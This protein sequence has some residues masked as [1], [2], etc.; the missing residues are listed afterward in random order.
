MPESKTPIGRESTQGKNARVGDW[1]QPVPDT[2]VPLG[3][4]R[5]R[6]LALIAVV[7][8]AFAPRRARGHL[9]EAR[10]RR[11]DG[12]RHD[13]HDQRLHPRRRAADRRLAGSDPRPRTRREPPGHEPDRRAVLRP[14]RLC[15]ADVRHPWARRLGRLRHL[16]GATRDR[17][18][19]AARASTSPSA[20]TSTTTR[21]AAGG[22]PT[23]PAS[24]GRPLRRACRSRRST[25]CRRGRISSAR[26]TGTASPK[27]GLIAGLFGSVPAGRLSPDL[28]WLASPSL[29]Q[30]RDFAARRSVAGA[31]PTVQ[32]SGAD[33][34]GPPGLSV[35]QRPGDRH[36]PAPESPQAPL[37]RRQRA[38][39]VE[40]P[41]RRHQLLDDVG[42]AWLDHFVKGDD[43]GVD[44]EPRVQIAPD[45]WT[46]KPAEFPAL[47][48]THP[49]SFA[50]L[51]GPKRVGWAGKIVRPAGRARTKIENFGS[52]VVTVRATTTPGWDRLVARIAPRRRRRAR[53]SRSAQ[54]R[55]RHVPA[56]GRTRS[57]CFRRSP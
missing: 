14:L 3:A 20:R 37:L 56:P 45:R 55:S 54:A 5:L 49:L 11:G 21:S 18:P 41:G 7:T 9:H 44:E 57:R 31:I 24:S 15:G 16:R 34:P 48:A 23:G 38:R 1:L 8:A 52:P 28:A 27:S 19:E 10:R 42:R 6:A 36:V 12:R 43:N 22:F 35:R 53:R 26:S 4:V 50:L 13:D 40:L 30:I 33:D 32:D 47:P 17:R 2:D 39:S 46:G 29:A 51:G 25:S